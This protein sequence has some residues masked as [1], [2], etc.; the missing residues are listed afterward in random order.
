MRSVKFGNV[1]A[2]KKGRPA[3]VDPLESVKASSL[4]YAYEIIKK[5][6]FD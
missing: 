5:E 4:V 2:K 3:K 6:E 1:K